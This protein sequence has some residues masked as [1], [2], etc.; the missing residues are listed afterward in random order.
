MLQRSL[1]LLLA[2]AVASSCGGSSA[3]DPLDGFEFEPFDSTPIDAAARTWTFVP[4]QGSYCGDGSRGGVG[5]NPGD[6]R[7]DVLIYLSGGG[8]CWDALTCYGLK[9][10][11]HLGGYDPSSLTTEVGALERGGLLDRTDATLPWK[12][13]SFVYVPYCT[14]DVHSGEAVRRHDENRPEL[15]TFHVGARNLDAY[16]SRLAATFPDARRVWI[17][18][19][20]AGG[21]G[22]TVNYPLFAAA[23]PKAEVHSLADS[24]QL[25]RPYGAR[26][27]ELNAAWNTRVPEGCEGCATDFPKVIDYL[28]DRYPDRRFGLL[29]FEED[30]VLTLYLG[31]PSGAIK[32]PTLALLR[33]QYDPNP[34]TRYFV[35][36]GTS[37]TMLGSFKDIVGPGGVTLKTWVVRWATGDAAWA[38]AR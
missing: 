34:F 23:F 4:V 30:R 31:F 28:V 12:D 20:S 38:N 7:E 3:E 25:V 5:F 13:A 10:A 32:E 33:E 15:R 1:A 19:S 18:G 17:M 27:E 36:P 9:V 24:A 21:F 22:V 8:A 6:G 2:A 14:G 16:L 37:H 35:L 29:A 26:A 11:S